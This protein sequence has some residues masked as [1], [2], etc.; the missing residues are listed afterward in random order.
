MQDRAKLNATEI[1]LLHM[2][3][4]AIEV[5]LER[6]KELEDTWPTRPVTELRA[7]YLG[8][9]GCTGPVIIQWKSR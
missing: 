9:M 5:Q 7:H 1:G 8:R 4:H 3:D 2:A 6:E